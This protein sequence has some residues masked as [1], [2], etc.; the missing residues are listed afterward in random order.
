MSGV[1][2]DRYRDRLQ[3]LVGQACEA[4]EDRGE[5]D[6]LRDIAACVGYPKSYRTI[7]AWRNGEI[8]QRINSTEMLCAIASTAWHRDVSEEEILEYLEEGNL[9][10]SASEMPEELKEFIEGPYRDRIRAIVEGKSLSEINRTLRPFGLAFSQKH[11]KAL[12]RGNRVGQ[13][14]VSLFIAYRLGVLLIEDGDPEKALHAFYRHVT[15]KYAKE[16]DEEGVEAGLVGAIKLMSDRMDRMEAILLAATS[17][18]SVKPVPKLPI[19]ILLEKAGATQAEAIEVAK[20]LLKD[21]PGELNALMPVLVG[22]RAVEDK[23]LLALRSVLNELDDERSWSPAQIK[24]IYLASQAALSG[25][26]TKSKSRLPST[27]E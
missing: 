16:S 12:K 13:H 3:E 23:D 26:E 20:G 14:G 2:M 17:G 15:G 11:L 25:A 5:G 6:T 27:S 9:N 18:G 8:K 7:A 4:C 22:D 19:E 1:N 24:Q 10:P 21:I